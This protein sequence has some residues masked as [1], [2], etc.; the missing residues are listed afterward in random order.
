MPLPK[1]WNVDN[2]RIKAMT[3]QNSELD[4]NKYDFLI[5]GVSDEA[6]EI[7]A[8]TAQAANYT[9]GSCTGMISCPA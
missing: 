6:L 3:D 5:N 7:A 2:K 4:L 1:S 9:L 8:G